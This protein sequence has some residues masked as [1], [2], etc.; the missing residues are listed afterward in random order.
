MH[1]LDLHVQRDVF[2]KSA[3]FL[4]FK[5]NTAEMLSQTLTAHRLI[6]H[7]HSTNKI[8][9][10]PPLG[11]V[12]H[13]IFSPIFRKNR[14]NPTPW[15]FHCRLFPAQ[16]PPH[17]HRPTTASPPSCHRSPPF[18]YPVLPP[19]PPTVSLLFHHPFRHP[20]SHLP[21]HPVPHPFTRSSAKSTSS[22]P[23]GA[24]VLPNH[25]SIVPPLHFPLKSRTDTKKPENPHFRFTPG[26]FGKIGEVFL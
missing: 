21:R 26:C 13:A 6:L 9:Q 25:P 22:P 17:H 20:F 7:S 4:V 2:R 16:T 8:Q 5:L 12:L 11:K 15:R 10:K 3:G 1:F 14:E 24:L 19:S 23:P 18:H